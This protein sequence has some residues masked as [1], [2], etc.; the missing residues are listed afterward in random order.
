MA[1]DHPFFGVGGWG[2]RQF[3]H[4]Y[5]TPDEYQ[6]M[7]RG[8]GMANV[9]NDILQF[10]CEH[11]VVGFGL[12]LTAVGLLLAPIF[13]GVRLAIQAPPDSEWGSSHRRPVL[14]RIPP[15]AWCVLAGTTATVVH[16]LIDIPF[17][18]PAFLIA[19]TLCLACTPA[20]L[21]R[22]PVSP[23]N[24]SQPDPVP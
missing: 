17:R 11:G 12:M 23:T 21:P 24:T 15:V 4:K 2:Y 6:R 5:V 9:H 20:F 16:S 18:S 14:L 19:W 8:K 1:C 7:L 13:R 10:L 3:A 22:K